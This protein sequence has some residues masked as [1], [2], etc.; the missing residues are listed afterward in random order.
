MPDVGF[1]YQP[2]AVQ[3]AARQDVPARVLP[4]EPV[5]L[6][7]GMTV[8]PVPFQWVTS[9]EADPE[10]LLQVPTATQSV[11]LAHETELSRLNVHP[12][13]FATGTIVHVLPFHRSDKLAPG[14]CSHMPTAMHD[15][16][17]VHDTAFSALLY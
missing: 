1:T 6:G 3:R 15:D 17:L 12:A 14:L 5:G 10:P 4:R 2:A 8:H 11:A 7:L 13:G 16:A 9:V